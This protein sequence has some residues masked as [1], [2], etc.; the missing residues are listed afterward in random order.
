MNFA[1]LPPEVNSW[2]MCAG[3]GSAALTAA[4][5]AWGTLAAWLYARLAD[6]RSVASQMTDATPY[7]EWLDTTAARSADAATRAEKAAGAF[8]AASAAM[9]PLAV[10]EANRAQRVSLAAT[11]CLGQLTAAIAATEAEYD[12]MW[13]RD[14]AA[15]HAYARASAHAAT[16][17]PFTSPTDVGEP[18]PQ[19]VSTGRKVM[20]AIPQALQAFSSSP[21]TTVDVPLAAVTSPLSKLSSLTTP[22]D[23]ALTHLNSMNKAAALHAATAMLSRLRNPSVTARVGRAGSTG[24]LS[25]PPTWARVAAPVADI[26]RDATAVSRTPS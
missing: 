4:A 16:M 23:I 13:A 6:Y 11:N 12:Q 25:V 17:T 9:A 20:T 5:K 10:V 21:L 22:S 3:P 2:R 8:E 7:L 15:M 26:S 19:V 18:A 1:T 14:A 24:T